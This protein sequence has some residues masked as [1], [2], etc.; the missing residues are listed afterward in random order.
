MMLLYTSLECN[1]SR[2]AVRHNFEEVTVGIEK[3]NAVVVAPVDQTRTLH[4]SRRQIS[5]RCSEILRTDP[6]GMMAPAEWMLNYLPTAG[7]IEGVSVDVKKREILL[8][9]L[10]KHLVTQVGDHGQAEYSGIKA[11]GTGE[12]GNLQTKMVEPLEL[13]RRFPPMGGNA[14][15]GI[16]TEADAHS[17]TFGLSD[18][19]Q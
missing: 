12:F 14:A 7:G 18:P 2:S 4:S 17:N 9:A 5:T 19:V 6:E 15:A 11:L 8:A 10:Q 1:P 16:V 3:V 13:H